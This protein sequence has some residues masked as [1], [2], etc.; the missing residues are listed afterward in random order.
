MS[1]PFQPI[2]D[3]ISTSSTRHKQQLFNEI[4]GEPENFLEI[5]VSRSFIQVKPLILTGKVRNPQTHFG[6]EAYTDYEIICRVCISS[7]IDTLVVLTIDQHSSIQ[8][9]K[10][11]GAQKILGVRCLPQDLGAGDH[12]GCNS[13]VAGQDLASAEQI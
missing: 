8:K 10:Q 9:K 2:S 5:E 12:E 7:V 13:S 4:Y 1:K 3:V 6:S 11:Q